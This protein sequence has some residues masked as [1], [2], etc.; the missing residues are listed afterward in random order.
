MRKLKSDSASGLA[1]VNRTLLK[2][3]S[4]PIGKPLKYLINLLTKS[5]GCFGWSEDFWCS[6]E[7]RKKHFWTYW[8]RFIP[9][10]PSLATCA[11]VAQIAW[12]SS[13][14][15][16]GRWDGWGETWN[17]ILA[18]EFRSWKCT[19]FL[20]EFLSWPMWHHKK[21]ASKVYNSVYVWHAFEK[22]FSISW[23]I[24]NVC[25]TDNFFLTAS[26]A[27]LIRMFSLNREY[28]VQFGRTIRL[29]IRI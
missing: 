18:I 24:K 15:R 1:D 6:S 12:R 21:T 2:N 5:W 3:V 14:R 8:P 13:M 9:T 25:L 26:V 7:L 11:V 4:S 16:F 17:T 20:E 23:S 27:K 29:F 28:S 19:Q 22:S 10:S